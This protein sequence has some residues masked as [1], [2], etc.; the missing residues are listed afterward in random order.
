MANPNTKQTVPFSITPKDA[1]G[2]AVDLAQFP[3]ALTGITWTA[4]NGATV[5]AA[6]N[7]LTA[8]VTPAA[9]G[10]V[11]VGVS[12]TNVAGSAVSDSQTVTFDAFVPVVVSLNEVSGAPV[13]QPAA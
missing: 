1:A 7:G 11:V 6:E 2:N 13:D 3:T 9:V 5:V 8:V 10:D 4:G 12:G